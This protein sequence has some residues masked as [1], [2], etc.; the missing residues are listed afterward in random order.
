MHKNK[1]MQILL[2]ASEP[3]KRSNYELRHVPDTK[4][5]EL[6]QTLSDNIKA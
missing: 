3:D 1:I 6:A 2:D 5:E 4:F